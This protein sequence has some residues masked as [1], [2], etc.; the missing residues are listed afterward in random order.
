MSVAVLATD[1][2]KL[3]GPI[4]KNS[5][6]AGVRE[7]GVVGVAAAVEAAADSPTAIDAVFGRGIGAEGVLSLKAVERGQLVA[8]APEKF[9]AEKEILVDG[10][11]QRLP[12]ERSIGAIKI[13]E[14][15]VGVE[16]DVGG[17][18]AGIVVTAGVGHAD[19]QVGGLTQVAIGAEMADDAEVLT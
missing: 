18:G 5:G 12:T 9:S 10:A 4:G 11:T 19:V 3:A 1:L 15:V 13:G 16:E 14:E 17:N 7:V 8:V 6:K 2:T